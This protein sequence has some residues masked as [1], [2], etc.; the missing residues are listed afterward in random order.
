VSP[1]ILPPAT[2]A[3][4]LNVTAVSPTATTFIS[5]WPSGLERPT[6]S[7]LNPNAGQIVPNA[8]PVLL[9]D[10]NKFNVYNNAGSTHIVIDL[11]GTFYF[12]PGLG[13]LGPS[14]A[15][16]HADGDVPTAPPGYVEGLHS[17]TAKPQ[18]R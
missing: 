4:S 14:L 18:L 11:V 6:V 7:T 16:K 8:A 13:A 1:G 12:R 9:G 5:V 15:F 10:E 3:L 2:W 17:L